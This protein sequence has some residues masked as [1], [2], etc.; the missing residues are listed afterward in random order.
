MKGEVIPKVLEDWDVLRLARGKEG[1]DENARVS[2]R[3]RKALD[4]YTAATEEYRPEESGEARDQVDLWM[5]EL[6]PDAQF[7][8]DA[9][10][11]CFLSENL[12]RKYLK[13]HSIISDEAK[14]KAHDYAITEQNRK[15][16]ANISF[17]IRKD[18]DPLSYL[19]MDQLAFNAEGG[20]PQ[21]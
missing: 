14:Q 7:N 1:D 3:K 19:G 13:H 17:D 4:L 21:G 6:R 16:A 2:K 9:Y 5:D 11:D 12:V 8:V 18:N 20:K 10:V 15:A